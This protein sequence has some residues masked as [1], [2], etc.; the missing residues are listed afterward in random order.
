MLI[1]RSTA[2]MKMRVAAIVAVNA[3]TERYRVWLQLKNASQKPG[4]HARSMTFSP[5][6]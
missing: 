6:P 3:R 1:A 2:E 4:H 5:V